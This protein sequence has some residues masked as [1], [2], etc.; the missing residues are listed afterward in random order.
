MRQVVEILRLNYQPQL[1][2]RV[3]VRSGRIA[4][5]AVGDCLL[6]AEA[7]QLKWALPDGFT[8]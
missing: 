2:V 8:E 4:A 5:S 1:S 3:I 6:R 7:A